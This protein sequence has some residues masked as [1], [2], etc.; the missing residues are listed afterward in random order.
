M[1]DAI[2]E[3]PGYRG[4]ERRAIERRSCPYQECHKPEVAAKQAVKQVFAILG[5]NIEEPS[6]VEQFREGLRFGEAMHKFANKGIM[7]MVV[8]FSAAAAAA[9]IAG[10]VFKLKGQTP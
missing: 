6:E 10:I 4:K 7:T 5:V 3:V 1:C 2:I 8:V 9:F